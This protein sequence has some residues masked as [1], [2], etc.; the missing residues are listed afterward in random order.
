MPKG[1]PEASLIFHVTDLIEVFFFCYSKKSA[2]QALQF[3]H[4]PTGLQLS[5][6][7]KINSDVNKALL[8]PEVREEIQSMNLDIKGGSSDGLNM[9]LSSE[10]RKFSAIVYAANIKAEWE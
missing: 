5:I 9:H 7:K 4:A 3:P 1:S 6:Q 2:F 8:T 10:R